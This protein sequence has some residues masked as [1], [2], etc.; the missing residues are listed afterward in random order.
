M[1]LLAVLAAAIDPC[2]LMTADDVS[3]LTGWTSLAPASRKRYHMPQ[4]SGT[5][6]SLSATEGVV[7][8]TVPDSGTPNATGVYANPLANGSATQVQIQDGYAEIFN[9][10]A[11]VDKHH[12]HAVVKILPLADQATQEELTA[13]A[14]IVARRLP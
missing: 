12:R 14:E 7:V 5:T 4:E 3:R 2:S 10:S 11:Y 6:C 1:L 9:S 8:I 13:A